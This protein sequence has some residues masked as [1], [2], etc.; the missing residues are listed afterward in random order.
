MTTDA[1]EEAIGNT[2]DFAGPGNREQALPRGNQ[3]IVTGKVR[4]DKPEAA[5]VICQPRKRRA[6]LNLRGRSDTVF[7]ASGLRARL[8]QSIANIA[9]FHED[10]LPRGSFGIIDLESNPLMRS[11]I[12]ALINLDGAPVAARDAGVLGLEQVPVPAIALAVDEL[13][14]GAVHLETGAERT[15]ALLGYLDEPVELATLL[16]L[17]ADTPAILLARAALARFGSDVPL[18]MAG[19]WSLLDWRAGE[20]LMLMS[21]L[22]R[23]DPVLYARSGNRVAVAPSLDLLSRLDWVGRSIDDAGFLFAVGGATVRRASAERT[24]LGPVNSLEHGGCVVL[25]QEGSRQSTCTAFG[26]AEPWRGS[27]DE[28]M[29]ESEVLLRR[30]VRQR[31][32]RTSGASCLLS[33]GLDS[34]IVT[35]LTCAERAAGQTLACL[36]SA[37]PDGSGLK[38]EVRFAAI[39]ADHLGLPLECVTPPENLSFYRPANATFEISNG[40]SLSIRHYLYDALFDRAEA[41]GLPVIFDGAYGEWTL[42]SIMPLTSPKF[43]LRQLAKRLLGRAKRDGGNPFH[44]RVAQHRLANLP[45]PIEKALRDPPDYPISRSRRER[46]GYLSRPG[47]L[48]G[49]ATETRPGR[50]RMEYPFRDPRLVRLFAGFPLSYVEHGGL[51]RSPARHILAGQLPDSIR[52]R[53]KGLGFSPDYFQ[54]LQNDAQTARGRIAA[55]KAAD[56]DDWLDLDWLD[57]NLQRLAVEGANGVSDAFQVQ[58]TAMAA[59]YLLWW[60]GAG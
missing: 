15:T 24:M 51:D 11:G 48:L 35:W 7:H 25:T 55:F 28:A 53:P 9:P 42:T 41:L 20:G 60:R 5:F 39:V 34:S 12:Y 2:F 16:K 19:E 29:E 33:G 21:S 45:K 46:W 6:D 58:I 50:V 30:I 3:A 44:V 18:K 31:I 47:K 49:V 37:A 13:Q 36:C 8:L 56:I 59:E 32:A 43:R 14:P 40:P 26:A 23:R 54:R 10:A 57:S 1:E 52:L 27:F 4:I 17:P 38:D 22:A